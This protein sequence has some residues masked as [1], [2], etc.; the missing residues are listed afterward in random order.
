VRG[1]RDLNAMSSQ[2]QQERYWREQEIREREK[3]IME[4]WQPGSHLLDVKEKLHN[5][6]LKE[7]ELLNQLKTLL[8]LN[9]KRQLVMD[10]SLSFY[11]IIQYFVTRSWLSAPPA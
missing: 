10:N 3:A 11:Q 5:F 1:F 4:R 6:Q 2:L 7:S 8:S 9:K